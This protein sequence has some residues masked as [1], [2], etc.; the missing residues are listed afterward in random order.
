MTIIDEYFD[1]SCSISL[2]EVSYKKLDEA[3]ED[4]TLNIKDD[5][6]IKENLCDSDRMTFIFSRNLSFS[7]KALFDITVNFEVVLELNDQYKGTN[8]WDYDKIRNGLL[9]EKNVI[10]SIVMSRISLLIS[11]LTSAYGE[12]PI[13]TPPSFMSKVE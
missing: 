4:V 3:D 10:I 8:D 6:Q 7:P 2:D 13:I 1:G 9:S 5:I 12:R 11:Q